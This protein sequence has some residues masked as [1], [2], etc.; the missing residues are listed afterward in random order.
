[1]VRHVTT[2]SDL[3]ALS[4]RIGTPVEEMD[5]IL[6]YRDMNEEFWPWFGMSKQARRHFVH[7]RKL[8]D[9]DPDISS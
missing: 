3:L 5:I 1:M 6:Y 2:L 4:R 9:R 7:E 8:P